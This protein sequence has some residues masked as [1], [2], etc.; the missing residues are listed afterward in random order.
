MAVHARKAWLKGLSPKA[1]RNVP[2]LD[3]PLVYRLKAGRPALEVVLNGGVADLDAALGHLAHVDGVM[4]GRAAYHDPGLLGQVDRR[5]FGAGE[6]VG[7]LQ[8]VEAYRPY[9]AGQLARGVPL[10]A[11]TRHMLGLFAGQPGARTWRRVLTAGAVRGGGLEV[12][13]AALEAVVGTAE[14]AV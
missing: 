2:P 1:N 3:Y 11:M 6:D 7:P 8:A 5:L 14:L 9:M 4:L 12:L 10:N 13:D